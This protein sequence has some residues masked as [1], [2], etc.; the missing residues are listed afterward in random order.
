MEKCDND[1]FDSLEITA[2]CDLEFGFSWLFYLLE[3]NS[4]YLDDLQALRLVI[5]AFGLLVYIILS[6]IKG[7][8]PL[9][10]PL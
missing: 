10:F 6:K 5:V 4:K 1:G 2:S 9:S 3:N 8:L 7:K